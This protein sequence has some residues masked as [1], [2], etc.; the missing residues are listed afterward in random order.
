MPTCFKA[1]GCQLGILP[2]TTLVS[3]LSHPYQP[4][5]CHDL[6]RQEYYTA[7]WREANTWTQL[8]AGLSRNTSLF[9]CQYIQTTLLSL[10]QVIRHCIGHCWSTVGNILSNQS[11]FIVKPVRSP[12][13]SN[14][15]CQMMHCVIHSR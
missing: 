7:T 1:S 2:R 12:V 8:S 13:A 4:Y 15:S 11:A 6:G 5:D 14:G 3:A 9:S 10:R